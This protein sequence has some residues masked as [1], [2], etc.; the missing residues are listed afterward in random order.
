M[1]MERAHE[2]CAHSGA[3]CQTE[4]NRLI[5]HHRDAPAVA[6]DLNPIQEIPQFHAHARARGGKRSAGKRGTR[7]AARWLSQLPQV[8]S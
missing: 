4:Q 6:A 7:V 3:A 2:Q 8:R 5:G 1:A